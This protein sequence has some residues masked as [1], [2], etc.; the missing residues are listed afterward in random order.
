MPFVSMAVNKFMARQCP[1]HLYSTFAIREPRRETKILVNSLPKQGVKEIGLR[2]WGL[3]SRGHLGRKHS[4]PLIQ[5]GGTGITRT[6][7]R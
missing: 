3:L 2:S 1:T 6:K 4:F 5:S 7:Y